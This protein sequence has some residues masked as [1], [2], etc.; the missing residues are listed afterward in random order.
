MLDNIFVIIGLSLG[1]A[2]ILATASY[3]WYYYYRQRRDSSYDVT[4]LKRQNQKHHDE[5]TD[6]ILSL[7]KKIDRVQ[8]YLDGIPYSPDQHKKGLLA[9]GLEALTKYDYSTAREKFIGILSLNPLDSERISVYIMTG[10]AYYSQSKLSQ[11]LE[12]YQKAE[13]L[14]HETS[15]QNGLSAALGNI[16]LIYRGLGKPDEAL[17]YLKEAL[18]IHKKIGYE[19]G[20]ASDLG[21]IGLIY[22]DLGKPG[23]A[24]KYLKGS[25]KIA[26]KIKNPHIIDIV[27]KAIEMI[28]KT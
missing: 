11:A 16:G 5:L 25:L 3:A 4:D 23:E 28:E 2:G 17:K 21:N 10:N 18:E 26:E 22:S 1:I 14:S 6:R 12:E 13:N 20:T 8:P 27:S 9:K 15:D 24:L 19:Q 7:E